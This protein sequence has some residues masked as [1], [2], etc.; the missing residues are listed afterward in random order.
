VIRYD[1]S[2]VD[3]VVRVSVLRSINDRGIMN[4]YANG[5][6]SVGNEFEEIVDQIVSDAETRG[7]IAASNQEHSRAI[8]LGLRPMECEEC[9]NTPAASLTLRRQVGM[10]VV[11]KTETIEAVLC[12]SCGEELRKWIQKQNALKGW[13]GLRSAAMNPAVIASNEKN[14]KSFK[15]ELA[16]NSNGT[17]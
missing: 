15:N 8:T 14:Y 10:I 13:T 6:L 5:T 12:H 2:D 4:T 3:A 9:A 16:R 7:A 11:M 17:S 1:L